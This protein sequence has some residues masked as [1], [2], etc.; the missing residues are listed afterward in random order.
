MHIQ[1]T[2]LH[3]NPDYEARWTRIETKLDKL[4]ETLNAIR[5]AMA[6]KESQ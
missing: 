2:A 6:R 5:E 4:E 1:S 3:R